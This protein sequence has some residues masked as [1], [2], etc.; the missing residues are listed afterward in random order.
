LPDS[1]EVTTA[2]DVA[3]DATEAPA[4]E[5]KQDLVP[6][7]GT[8]A[9]KFIR[10]FKDKDEEK[11]AMLYSMGNCE[12][13]LQDEWIFQYGL[14]Y[15]PKPDDKDIYRTIRIE[16]LP[17]NTTLDR[18]LAEVCYGDIFS[19]DLLNTFPITG[20]HTARVVFIRQQSAMKFSKYAK[21]KGLKIKGIR[22]CVTL[23][24]IATYPVGLSLEDSI[25]RHG[26][27]RCV[28]ISVTEE[29][30]GF[31]EDTLAET[32]LKDCVETYSKEYPDMLEEEIANVKICMH[33]HSVKAAIFAYKMFRQNS[34][35]RDFVLTYEKD[36]CNR[37][38]V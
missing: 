26:C 19:A 28:A 11:Q 32:Y 15:L 5:K 38:P 6:W 20:Y 12:I 17:E 2:K 24:K 35:L 30:V 36:P 7:D 10:L 16:N 31:I 13:K 1:P 33:F 4:G 34:F 29:F 37:I 21:K 27:T 8:I 14:R 25:K 18:V 9:W 3:I 22:A 23:E